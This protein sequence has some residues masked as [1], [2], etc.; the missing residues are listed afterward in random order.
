MS[1]QVLS[2]KLQRADPS[3]SWGFN[4]QG[5][6]DFGSP[7][8]IQKVNPNSLADQSS[9][10]P[11]DYIL[12]IG[13]NI[14]EHFTHAQ[15]R[16]AIIAQGN[17]LE[18]TL[19]RGAAPRTEDYGFNFQNPQH[20]LLN[21][22][23]VNRAPVASPQVGI[24]LPNNKALLTQSYNSPMGLYSNQNIADTLTN[25]LKNDYQYSR[26]SPSY[27][28]NS[29]LSSSSILS[30]SF[31]PSSSLSLTQKPPLPIYNSKP[32]PFRRAETVEPRKLESI[33]IIQNDKENIY[34]A[35]PVK[36]DDFYHVRSKS[37]TL[38]ENRN[39]V[40]NRRD[41]IS[42]RDLLK[43]IESSFKI[44]E[45]ESDKSEIVEPVLKRTSWTPTKKE[46][47]R[48]ISCLND[49][50]R[51]SITQSK[52]FK[53][54]QQTLDNGLAQSELVF[55]DRIQKKTEIRRCSIDI[56]QEKPEIIRPVRKLSRLA[57]IDQKSIEENT[58]K[59]QIELKKNTR[60]QSVSNNQSRS[61]S[62]IGNYSYLSQL[63]ANSN[64]NNS[65]NGN[66]KQANQRRHSYMY[67]YGSNFNPNY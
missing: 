44:E 61:S 32:R 15:A 42:G 53:L 49:P 10:R 28:S 66:S 11:G 14:V 21:T 45:S 60:S 6:R 65:N 24:Q 46:I 67:R 7:F 8:V 2:I 43:N 64:N 3:V 1:L 63:K 48:Q 33:K 30:N 57:S 31:S 19:Q 25:T 55:Y 37:V 26:N 51:Q 62:L 5:G 4:I 12:R 29:S 39:I 20:R 13:N 56:S 18:L 59:D 34:T 58:Q 52:S 47:S 50:T 22:E 54:L 38:D 36:T 9:V 35:I 40:Y 16:E 41:S 27:D 23:N 17:H